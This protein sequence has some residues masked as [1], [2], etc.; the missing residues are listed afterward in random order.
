MKI[1]DAPLVAAATGG[2]KIPTGE[3]GDKAVTV[4]QIKDYVVPPTGGTW[5][6][7]VTN[8]ANVAV[9]AAFSGI[10]SRIG[11][12][13]TAT[14]VGNIDPTTVNIV[15]RFRFSLPVASDFAATTDCIGVSAEGNVV[16]TPGNPG[17]VSADTV[18]NEAE[19]VY[20]CADN[21]NHSITITFQYRVL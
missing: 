11:T 8:I 1:N 18:N 2:M 9:A 4:D 21:T 19:V 16:N 20:V 7:V 13:I 12:I 15:T 3:V 14:V 10:Y 17:N 5:V 6:P